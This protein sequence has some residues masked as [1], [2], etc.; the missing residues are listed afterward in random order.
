MELEG[1]RESTNV[2]DRRSM[3][4]GTKVGL[5]GIGGLI[6]AGLITLLMGGN[7][8][9]V[10]QQAGGMA[11]QTESGQAASPEQEE[12]AVFASRVIA[13]T[14]DVWTQIFKEYGIGQYPAPTMVLYT[15]RTQTA[16][17]TGTA[18][19]GPFY[20]SGDQKVYLD[21]AFFQTMD[22]QLG[23]RGD[24]SS[25]A[26]AYVIAHEVGHHIEYLMGTLDKAHQRMQA[27]N[28]TNANKYSVR[29]ELMADF[30]AGVWAHYE[31]RYFNSISDRDLQEAIDCAQK[32]G[33]DYLQKRA[34]GRV[35]PESF[36][37]GT[38]AQRMKWFKLGYQTGDVRRATTFQESDATL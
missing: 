11:I 22:S 32:I 29:L 25:L 12:L 19:V 3:S 6:I 17:G 14:E 2:E 23:V 15:G 30:Y 26:K 20:C 38:S 8:T 18:A 37:H 35:S 13:S 21:L 7:I 33:D 4:T 34:Q 5:G 16:C 10:L 9:D 31:N 36:T 28:Q 27:T 24:N 1:R